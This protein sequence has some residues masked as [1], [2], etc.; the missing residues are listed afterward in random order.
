MPDSRVDTKRY[1]TIVVDPPWQMPSGGPQAGT[2]VWNP[3]TP[4]ALPYRTMTPD[5][6]A[7][8]AVP[9]L[10]E[11]PGFRVPWCVTL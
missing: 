1:R 11:R 2:R 10:A 8:L 3:G 5:E 6:I 4:S 7:A 9:S